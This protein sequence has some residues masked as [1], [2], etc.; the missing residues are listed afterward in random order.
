MTACVNSPDDLAVVIPDV[1]MTGWYDV[2]PALHLDQ[3]SRRVTFALPPW[4]EASFTRH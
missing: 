3:D 2:R 1:F 4:H